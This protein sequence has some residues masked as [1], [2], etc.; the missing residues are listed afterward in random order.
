MTTVAPDVL[1]LR[2]GTPRHQGQF[3][4]F[5]LLVFFALIRTDVRRILWE[6]NL[7]FARATS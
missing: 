7:C 1:D 3:F 2:R 5:D 6:P 4:V